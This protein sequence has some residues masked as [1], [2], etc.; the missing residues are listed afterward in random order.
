MP[1]LLYLKTANSTAHNT[2]VA[3][4]TTICS[5]LRTSGPA[6]QISSLYGTGSACVSV[7]MF[8][9]IVITPRAT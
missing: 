7:P 9:I 5:T 4:I 6:F 2:A 8:G 3:P 1:I